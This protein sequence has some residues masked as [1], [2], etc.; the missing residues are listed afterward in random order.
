MAVD[1]Q[2]GIIAVGEG[3]AAQQSLLVQHVDVLLY[4]L[5]QLFGSVVLELYVGHETCTAQLGENVL[6]KGAVYA[7]HILDFTLAD[8][9]VAVHR[10]DAENEV[11]VFDVGVVYQLLEAFPVLTDAL[12]GNA[13]GGEFLRN[14]LESLV[15]RAH[16][17]V[18]EDVV[19]L[20]GTIGRC[21]GNDVGAGDGAAAVV[22]HVLDA[23][24]VFLDGLAGELVGTYVG[25]VDEIENLSLN[26]FGNDF[27]VSVSC[28]SVSTG[29]AGKLVG[30]VGTVCNLD[31]LGECPGFLFIFNHCAAHELGFLHTLYIR[32]MYVLG[33][34]CTAVGNS[35]EVVHNL[36]ALI[37]E[38]LA[39]NF[40]AVK[41][42]NGSHL[43]D[44]F[45]VE[46]FLGESD[47]DI[48]VDVVSDNF[49][50]LGVA[51]NLYKVGKFSHFGNLVAGNKCHQGHYKN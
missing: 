35:L 51:F 2:F 4:K 30:G 26:L 48:S 8:V 28:G 14:L 40:L 50:N 24:L 39:G 12:G 27:L 38:R 44:G 1:V 46:I 42:H 5:L 34:A 19:A 25:A 16:T 45:F 36:L 18:G 17:L 32:E 49:Q 31:V 3:S 41:L 13:A 20:L 11:L 29:A 37:N 22:H 33:D 15:C 9:G 47:S 10:E 43:K 7:G 21:I 23:G 6:C